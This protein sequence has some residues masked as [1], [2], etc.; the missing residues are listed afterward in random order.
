MDDRL[1][2]DGLR[3]ARTVARLGSF[4]GA[5]RASGVTQPSLSN[6]IARLE[7]R[8]G[9]SLFHRSTR[10]V[11]P[12]EFGTHLLPLIDRVLT[13]LDSLT[14]EAR[15]LTSPDRSDIRIGLSP[16]IDPRIVA[17]THSAV[18]EFA[19]RRE[20]MLREADMRDLRESL[21]T[22]DLDIVLV[23][24]VEQSPGFRHQIIDSEPVVVIDSRSMTTEP[25]DLDDVAISKLILVPDSCGL[26]T[27]TIGLFTGRNTEVDT[28]PGEP[29]SYR[30]LE[31][32]ATLGLGTAILPSSKLSTPD[33]T[34]R[35]LF[36][37]GLEVEIFY[38]A[39]WHENSVLAPDLELLAET[40]ARLAAHHR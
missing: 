29:A 22:G 15:R 35:P 6:G 12:T 14:A 21:A 20:L 18:Q 32:W 33:I 36:D 13:E 7:K 5:A 10:G 39:I 31:Q 3:Y 25:V 17:R 27:F 24:A 1:S 11:T 4:T 28:Y 8:L 23:P 2:L 38:E 16:L 34:H 40:L 19:G 9:A 37:D 30:M 26:T